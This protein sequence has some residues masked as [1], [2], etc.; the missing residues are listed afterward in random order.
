MMTRVAV[1]AS[2]SALLLAATVRAGPRDGRV[3]QERGSGALAIVVNQAN[4]VE[5]LTLAQLRRIFMFDTQ[6]WPNGRKITVVLRDKG[7]PERGEAIRLVCD[8][9]EAAYDDHILFQ[10]F[11]GSIGWG[12]RSITSVS[13]M[14]RFIF[15][16]P[17]AI[18][19]VPADQV[20]GT[21][22]LRIDGLLPTDPDY[23]LRRGAR[24]H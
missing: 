3:N 6:T 15:N 7:Q 5:S 11:R 17:G 12:P 18:G 4:P 9:S 14:L 16:V 2:L 23:P 10:T 8:M 1:A 19:Y 22:V 13:A 20:E 21:K 24:G